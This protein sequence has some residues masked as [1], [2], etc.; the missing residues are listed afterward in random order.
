MDLGRRLAAL[1]VKR[2]STQKKVAE[3][4][5]ISRRYVA[6]IEAGKPSLYSDRLFRLLDLLAAGIVIEDGD[7]A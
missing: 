7:V 3:A 2:R 1:R 5:V 6:E 4:L